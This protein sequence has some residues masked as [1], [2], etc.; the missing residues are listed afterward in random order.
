MARR[1]T[2]I[3]ARARLTR[4]STGRAAATVRAGSI[5]SDRASV[6]VVAESSGAGGMDMVVVAPVVERL[7]GCEGTAR[8][9][10][11]LGVEP[12]LLAAHPEQ[13]HLGVGLQE[14]AAQEVQPPL[15]GRAAERERLAM[16]EVLHGVGRDD[17]GVVAVRVRADEDITHH[18]D[19]DR[20]R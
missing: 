11:R 18:L 5:G 4:R 8:T 17:L 3:T 14:P 20:R 12:D 10:H 15:E 1:M 7:A 9:G 13:L 2:A 6:A 16:D 19:I